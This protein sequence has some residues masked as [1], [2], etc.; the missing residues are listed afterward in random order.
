MLSG[1]SS[2][3]GR[4]RGYKVKNMHRHAYSRLGLFSRPLSRRLIVGL[5][6]VALA[7]A[8]YVTWDLFVP[9]VYE[10][11]APMTVAAARS[12]SPISLPDA[13]TRVRIATYRQWIAFV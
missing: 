3:W 7:F 9:H 12:H 13:A 1:L 8:A 5:I 10:N 4:W 6:F 11:S 2:W